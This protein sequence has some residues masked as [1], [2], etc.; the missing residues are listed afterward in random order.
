[1]KF[2][3][4]FR[5]AECT[6]TMRRYEADGVSMRLDFFS[7]MLRVSM[8]RDEIPLVPTWSVWP[9]PGDCPLEGRDKLS[10]EGL[11][12]TAPEVSEDA[13]SLRFTLS[14]VDFTV[15]KKNFRIQARTEEGLLYADRS[16]LAYNFAGELGEGS[17]HYTLRHVD[18]RIFGLTKQCADNSHDQ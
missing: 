1:M 15:E 5:L 13:E 11:R 9:L 10:V 8:L 2:D 6:G 18:E 16:G 7:H 4:R 17:I 3:H 12:L 14:G